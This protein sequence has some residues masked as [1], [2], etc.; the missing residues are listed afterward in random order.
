ML[1]TGEAERTL[2]QA[3]A[4]GC[5]PLGAAVLPPP[6]LDRILAGKELQVGHSDG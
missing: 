1:N 6:S 5:T 2:F 4:T 3:A